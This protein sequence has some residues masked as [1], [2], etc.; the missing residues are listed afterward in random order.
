MR[1]WK[2]TIA[3]AAALLAVISKAI[4]AGHLDFATDGPAIMAAI[5]LLMAKDFNVS[6][7]TPK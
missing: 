2:T 1:N 3:G 6:G 4:T 5:G 7:T